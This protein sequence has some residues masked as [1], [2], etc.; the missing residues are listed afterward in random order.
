MMSGRRARRRDIGYVTDIS[1]GRGPEPLGWQAGRGRVILRPVT[2][3]GAPSQP[4]APDATSKP[5]SAA[6][7]LWIFGGVVI[8]A[9]LLTMSL[10][11]AGM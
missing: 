2:E 9:A 5:P 6:G 3:P 4:K 11:I 10:F 8:I 7:Y 1:G